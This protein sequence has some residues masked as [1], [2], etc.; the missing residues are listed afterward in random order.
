MDDTVIN[1]AERPNICIIRIWT[2]FVVVHKS[3]RPKYVRGSVWS[4]RKRNNS[5]KFDDGMMVLKV[6]WLVFWCDYNNHCVVLEALWV[7]MAWERVNQCVHHNVD[8]IILEKTPTML[9][10]LQNQWWIRRRSKIKGQ[11]F[12][13]Q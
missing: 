9:F 5:C 8:E 2:P 3:G 12:Y 11:Q 13:Y 7:A 6:V 4:G 1:Q 10:L